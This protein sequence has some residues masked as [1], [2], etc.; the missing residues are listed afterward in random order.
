MPGKSSNIG[1]FWQELKRRKVVRVI[2]VYAAAA[3][4]ILELVDIVA[5]SLG[6]PS[7]TLN[8]IIVLLCVGF[9]LA[10]ILSWIYDLT[11][12]GIKKTKPAHKTTEQP[13]Q[14]PVKMMVWKMA[15]F[16]SIVIILVLLI[17][18]IA[19]SRKSSEIDT[20]LE[21]SIAVLPFDNLSSNE[22]QAWFSDGI[23]D[24]IINQLSKISDF[25]VLSRTST[26]KYKENKKSVAEIGEELEVNFLIEGTVQKQESQIRIS[27]Q[28]IQVLNEGHIWSDLYDREWNDIQAIRK[29]IIYIYKDV[30]SGEREQK[31]GWKKVWNILKGPWQLIQIML[32]PMPD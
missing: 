3:F 19:G 16:M 12:E 30:F 31:K 32:W 13:K 15:T 11:P 9:V 17:L 22:D 4:V 5:P 27:V 24:V 25:R 2:T 6:L 14:A 28:L 23:T 21:K 8:F 18:N 20:E 7:W 29:L 10:I 26:L 1:Q